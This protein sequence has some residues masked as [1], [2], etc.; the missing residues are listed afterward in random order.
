MSLSLSPDAGRIV[1]VQALRAFVYGLGSVLI[2]VSLE[3]RGLSG[4]EVGGVL[5]ALLAGSSADP[6]PPPSPDDS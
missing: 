5:A 4:A 2:G 3:R 1:G 6:G